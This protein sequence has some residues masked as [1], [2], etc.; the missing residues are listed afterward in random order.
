[1]GKGAF[2]TAI[3]RMLK[4]ERL[5]GVD[6]RRYPELGTGDVH[7]FVES[8]FLQYEPEEYVDT[9]IT[10]P[11]FSEAEAHVRHALKLLDPQ[12]GVLAFL[13]RLNF[14]E[15]KERTAG[16]WKEHPPS[17]IYVLN[18]RPSFKKT[19]RPKIDKKTDQVVL[20]KKTGQPL[21]V[22]TGNDATA[23]GVFVW[24]MDPA[25]ADSTTLHWLEW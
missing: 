18:R 9:I 21:M 19:R 5:I 15:G 22:T 13:L 4:P 7:E 6:L 25:I 12:S 11:P 10:N 23:Y 1:M 24:E 14:L 2:A 3:S 8:D 16:F 20:S 17:R